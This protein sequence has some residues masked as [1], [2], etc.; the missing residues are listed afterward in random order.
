MFIICYDFKDDR[1]RTRFSKFLKRFGRKIQYSIYEI[2]NS[3]RLLKNIL[4]EIDLKYKKDFSNSDSIL[5]FQVCNR[6][7]KEII[8]YGYAKN[9][10]LDVVV[11]E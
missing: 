9:E 2:K 6:C 4:N 1:I 8:R 11:F 5:I 7:R 3:R 10:E